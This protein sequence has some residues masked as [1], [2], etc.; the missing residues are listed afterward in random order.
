M[1]GLGAVLDSREN[2]N[3]L[4]IEPPAN[5][6]SLHGL[7]ISRG[8]LLAILGPV[9]LGGL[10]YLLFR[11]S[12]VVFFRWLEPLQLGGLIHMARAAAEPVSPLV[13]GFMVYSL[14]ALLWTFSF[15]YAVGR[16]WA[17]DS[18]WIRAIML[19]LVL[20][21]SASFEIAQAMG[22]LSGVFDTD[23]LL[24]TLAGF[25]LSVFFN[26]WRERDGLRT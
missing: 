2:M 1:P 18:R 26:E 5:Q 23:D 25:V 22:W 17:G 13:P 20:A 7:G 16:L 9:C 6:G 19:A 8:D 3:P 10:I 14:P 12:T 4:A 15:A 24:A 21:A 11:P